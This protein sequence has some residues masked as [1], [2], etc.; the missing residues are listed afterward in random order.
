MVERSPSEV[1]RKAI[2]NACA[3]F[4]QRG[5]V[6][7]RGPMEAKVSMAMDPLGIDEWINGA[8]ES[9]TSTFAAEDRSKIPFV[10]VTP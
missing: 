5:R 6:K 7:A 3:G 9:P 8:V 10:L 1:G 2:L 4:R